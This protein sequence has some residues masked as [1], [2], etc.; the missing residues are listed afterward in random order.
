MIFSREATLG[1]ALSVRASVRP[2]VIQVHQESSRAK[3]SIITKRQ[4]QASKPSIKTKRQNHASKPSVKTKCLNQA[5]KSSLK[6][7]HHQES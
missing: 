3:L 6:I 2:F 5:S 1:L 4:N 7:K